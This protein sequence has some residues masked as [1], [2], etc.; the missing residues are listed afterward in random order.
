MT[1]QHSLSRYQEGQIL[2]AGP[3]KLLLLT[4]D[5]LLRFLARAQRGM[6]HGNYEEKHVGV[7]RAQM[8]LLELR[9]TLD[10]APAPDLAGGLARI[11][12]YLIEELAQADAEDDR[13]RLENVVSITSELRET[14]AE[15]IR[16]GQGPQER[17]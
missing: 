2:N 5:G 14:W 8:L 15:V 3:G 4:Y 17:T 9:R 6:E 7:V 10:F 11:Y 13:A 12:L 1:G 16:R